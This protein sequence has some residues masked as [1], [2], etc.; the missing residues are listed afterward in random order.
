MVAFLLNEGVRELSVSPP[1]VR[2][3]KRLVTEIAIE[4]RS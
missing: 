3:V 1:S 4:R 2:K